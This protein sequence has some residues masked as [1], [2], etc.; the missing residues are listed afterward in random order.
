M[1]QIDVE[2]QIR[3]LTQGTP[4]PRSR[5]DQ[6]QIFELSFFFFLIKKKASD[7]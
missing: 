1:L 4:S 7:K 2:A 5:S 3:D 6:I